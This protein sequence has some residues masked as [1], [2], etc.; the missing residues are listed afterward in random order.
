M[1]QRRY[2]APSAVLCAIAVAVQRGDALAMLSGYFGAAPM[3]DV[4]EGEAKH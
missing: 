2:H 4:S 3:A 1:D